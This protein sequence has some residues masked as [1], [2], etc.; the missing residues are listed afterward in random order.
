MKLKLFLQC[1]LCY[2]LFSTVK[3]DT[4]AFQ[5]FA[6]FCL[7]VAKSCQFNPGVFINVLQVN[8]T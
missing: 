6:W 8:L 2:N 3:T 4:S 7:V 5:Q 1:F